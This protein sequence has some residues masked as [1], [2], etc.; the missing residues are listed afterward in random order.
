MKEGKGLMGNH[1]YL[2]SKGWKFITKKKTRAGYDA[3]VWEDP[4]SF[5]QFTQTQAVAWQRKRDL[6][7][8]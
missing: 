5:Y 1:E 6:E 3:F 7:N 4:V 8:G 2:E